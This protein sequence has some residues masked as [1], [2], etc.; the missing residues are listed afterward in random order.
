MPR[1]RSDDL[2]FVHVSSFYSSHGGGLEAVATQLATRIARRGYRVTWH[3]GG[4]IEGVPSQRT[5]TLK[6]AS[7]WDPVESWFGAPVPL[8]SPGAVR[9]LWRSVESADLVHVHDYLYSGSLAALIAARRLGRTTVVTQHIGAIPYQNKI[10]RGLL[11]LS[12]RWLGR[13]MLSHSDR[14]I[15]VGSGVRE[16]F[17][18]FTSFPTAPALIHNGVDNEIFAPIGHDERLAI[19]RQLGLQA[20]RPV[21]LFVGRFVEK[22]GLKLLESAA[23]SIPEADWI[24]LGWG[25]MSPRN[26]QLSNVVVLENL[27]GRQLVPWYQAADLFVLPSYG[28][29]FPLVV[30][31][32]LACGTPVAVS[33]EIASTLTGA[34]TSCVYSLAERDQTAAIKMIR[35]LVHC[36]NVLQ[37]ARAAAVELSRQW[38]WENAVDHYLE[39]YLQL[40]EK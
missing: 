2:H 31:E 34:D 17:E 26:W 18:G 23:R 40:C 3:A 7:F 20:Q 10:A 5:L 9:S 30:Q 8:W 24:F 38:S 27:R 36:P 25:P 29:G 14:V 39:I 15:F 16:Y 33:A 13:H 21:L 4:S 12:N 28:E 1:A 37:Q 11:D 6:P 22:K 35:D 19:R 32:S